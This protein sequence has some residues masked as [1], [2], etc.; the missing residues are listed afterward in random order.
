METQPIYKLKTLSIWS[1]CRTSETY[2]LCKV[3]GFEAWISS[4][5]NAKAFGQQQKNDS[6]DMLLF[7]CRS[8]LAYWHH[9]A[10]FWIWA[11][12]CS[13]VCL[14]SSNAFFG[15]IRSILNSMYS[16]TIPCALPPGVNSPSSFSSVIIVFIALDLSIVIALSSIGGWVG[17]TA[18]IVQDVVVCQVDNPTCSVFSMNTRIMYKQRS[19]DHSRR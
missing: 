11:T 13:L 2:H 6:K 3:V 7:E 19:L 18:I 10:N 17:D 1:Q 8:W 5:A 16:E 14:T 12:R 4:K 15:P 9:I